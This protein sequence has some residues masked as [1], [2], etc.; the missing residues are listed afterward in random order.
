MKSRSKFASTI[1]EKEAILRLEYVF[2][3]YLSFSNRD[4][5][6]LRDGFK[7]VLLFEYQLCHLLRGVLIRILEAQ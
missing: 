6:R 3:T 4:G 5:E 7:S 1:L 2:Q